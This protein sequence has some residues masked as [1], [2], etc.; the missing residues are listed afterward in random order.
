MASDES[1]TTEPRGC[2]TPGA[3]SA[4]GVIAEHEAEVARLREALEDIANERGYCSACGRLAEQGESYVGCD[5][6][7]GKRCRW[8]PMDPIAYA[9]AA[10]RGEEPRTVTPPSPS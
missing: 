10:L 9:K 6:H 2:P 3:C 5:E 7:D 8:D 4:V 1:Q